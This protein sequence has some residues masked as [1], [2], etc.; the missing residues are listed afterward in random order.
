MDWVLFWTAAGATGQWAGAVATFLAVVVALKIAQD[1]ARVKVRVRGSLAIIQMGPTLSD[2]VVFEAVNAGQRPVTLTN[3]GFVIPNG[4][5]LL[6]RSLLT[7]FPC[8]LEPM[9]R[10]TR[11]A[12]QHELAEALIANGF[13][14]RGILKVFFADTAGCRHWFNWKIE[15][16][17]W[18][19]QPDRVC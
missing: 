16:S 19:P 7:G 6:M 2:V 1:A 3:M 5:Q 11:T 14:S 10:T 17:K 12:S 13:S 4:Q 15:P 18:N 9:D 8:K